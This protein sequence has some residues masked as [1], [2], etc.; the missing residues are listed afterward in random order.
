MF[1]AGTLREYPFSLL[2]E[3]F[4]HRG[5]TGLLEISSTEEAGFFYIKNGKVK[6]GRI[7]KNKGV[8]AV[9]IVGEL[10][11]GSFKFRPLEA[12]DYAR[13]VW[14]RSFGPTT[15]L[16]T[17]D[18]GRSDPINPKNL[19]AYAL[20]AFAFCKERLKTAYPH[21]ITFH[22][23]SITVR[24]AAIAAALQ[25][26]VDHNVIFAIT[27]TLL[28][29]VSGLCVYQLVY[30]DHHSI[31]T[32]TSIDQHVDAPAQTA[33]P[34]KAKTKRSANQRRSTRRPRANSR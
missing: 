29:S 18:A 16:A 8:A 17:G 3:I 14:Q 2:L 15:V 23:P 22:I 19:V 27:V 1:L 12:T 5:E 11:D 25:Q 20:A 34:T 30:G 28:L 7:G 9:K 4:L 6:D 31:D 21:G 32:S 26:G 13:V 33:T 24:S 10:K